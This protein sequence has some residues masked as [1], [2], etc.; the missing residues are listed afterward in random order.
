MTAAWRRGQRSPRQQPGAVPV[1]TVRR[2][3]FGERPRCLVGAAH[4]RGHVLP[5]AEVT[6]GSTALPALPGSARSVGISPGDGH[7]RCWCSRDRMASR[8]PLQPP[9]TPSWV[10][11]CWATG[12]FPGLSIS[13][14]FFSGGY[15]F[16]SLQERAKPGRSPI[17]QQQE[18]VLSQPGH[19]ALQEAA[20]SS[21]RAPRSPSR[22]G[23]TSGASEG[24]RGC[25]S[26]SAHAKKTLQERS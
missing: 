12:T 22:A 19:A 1:L 8:G 18:A 5:G 23:T 21:N 4:L 10:M 15:S 9:F 17:G 20:P 16:Q 6:H 11:R 26:P 7:A 25:P 2:A 3:V 13:L 24:P 14:V